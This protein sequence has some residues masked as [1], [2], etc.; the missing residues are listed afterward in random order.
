MLLMR[1]R[2]KPTGDNMKLIFPILAEANNETL[3]SLTEKYGGIYGL[4]FVGGDA[5]AIIGTL[6][7]EQ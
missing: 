6:E 2:T 4:H 3:N 7:Y 5:F 1:S